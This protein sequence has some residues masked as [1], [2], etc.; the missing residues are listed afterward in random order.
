[1]PSLTQLGDFL[2]VVFGFSLIIFIHEMGHFLAARWAGIRVLAF[3]L[4]FGSALFSYRKGFGFR[5]GSSEP[6]YKR[7]MKQRG[8]SETEA[9]RLKNEV[10]PTEYRFNILPLGG[11]VKML[12][13]DDS[14]PSGERSGRAAHEAGDSY[15]CAPVYKRMVV[16]SAGVIMNIVS[17]AILFIIVFSAGLKTESP[18]IGVVVSSA[19]GH[20]AQ[21]TGP[22]GSKLVGLKPGDTVLSVDGE[23]IES[24]K[25]IGLAVAMSRKDRPLE[26]VVR[27]DGID[28][29]L[30]FIATPK[31]DGGSG[32]LALGIG[33]AFTG[34]VVGGGS[35]KLGEEAVARLASA[36][37]KGVEPGMTLVDDRGEP[38]DFGWIEHAMKESGGKPVLTLWRK[39]DPDGRPIGESVT[40]SIAPRAEFETAAVGKPDAYP[41]DH[42]AGLTP[43]MTVRQPS[44][45]GIKAGLQAG[46]I[47]LRVGGVQWPCIDEGMKQI[48][49]AGG[50]SGKA[51]IR[52]V[53]LRQGKVLDLG[54]VPVNDGRIGFDVTTSAATSNLLTSFPD[55]KVTTEAGVRGEP[56][57]AEPLGILPGSRLVKVGQTATPTLVDA[58][59]AI[60][61]AIAAADKAGGAAILIPLTIE[62]PTPA[63]QEPR[64]ETKIMRLSQPDAAAIA[65]LGW[66]NALPIDIFEPAQVI[67]KRT[68][69]VAAVAKGLQETK[70]MVL[71]TYLTFARLFQGSV[72]VEH[73]KGPIGIAHTGT[74]LAEKG[75]IWLLFFMAAV[76]VNLA[77]VNFLPLP[78]VD[79]GHFCFL[80]WEQFTGKPVSAAVQNITALAGLAL[81]GVVF[82]MTTYNDLANLLWR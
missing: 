76:S 81:I 36:G 71:T 7:W 3:A 58:R 40:V 57:A 74:I 70:K 53:V 14:D 41:T 44:E 82:L 17:A 28:E 67:I 51:K 49:S 15:L 32:M 35:P 24:F 2:L 33:P 56:Y 8:L 16:I 6:E 21:A 46:D 38:R 39:T 72:K 80:L 42:L 63:G 12:G 73:L 52:V 45:A 20:A 59:A 26:V 65:S 61:A 75:F 4:G 68:G 5:R 10:S 29:P 23:P 22:G 62:L 9:G 27:R 77:V 19:P 79:G 48:R 78:I 31:V 18:R 34:R 54:E 69:P 25:D 11:Y 13:Q 1:M 64:L 30:S 55:G 50:G 43:L 37:V 60:Q 66:E 47:F